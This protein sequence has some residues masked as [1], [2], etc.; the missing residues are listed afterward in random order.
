[1]TLPV[2]RATQRQQQLD[3]GRLAGPV[4]PEQPEH[5]AGRDVE[6]DV[7]HRPRAPAAVPAGRVHLADVLEGGRSHGSANVGAARPPRKRRPGGPAVG[8]RLT[9][10]TSGLLDQG[11]LDAP[12]E[13]PLQHLLDGGDPLVV[14]PDDQLV[15][16]DRPGRGV[17]GLPGRQL[18]VA[19]ELQGPRLQMD[20]VVGSNRYPKP[21]VWIW[22][23]RG[24]WR[25]PARW[26]SA[27]STWSGRGRP[28]P[29][30]RWYRPGT[31]ATPWSRPR[32][33]RSARRG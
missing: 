17:L 8:R 18:D 21:R 1:M 15:A 3:Q 9:P 14:R 5:L 27:R 13:E 6:G 10:G 33:G 22:A 29:R 19:Q 24:R 12:L 16:L 23:G 26:P 7:R 25:S 11:H 28:P 20:V 2:G 31:W 30:S 4:G 32:P